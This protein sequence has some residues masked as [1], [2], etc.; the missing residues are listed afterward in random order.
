MA[1]SRATVASTA[2]VSDCGARRTAAVVIVAAAICRGPMAH[3]ATTSATGVRRVSVCRVRANRCKWCKAAGV[4]GVIIHPVVLR[5]AAACRNHNANAIIHCRRMV[6][7]IVRVAVRNIVRATHTHVHPVHWIHVSSSVTKWMAEISP[8]RVLLALRNGY[9]S[10]DV[11]TRMGNVV[12]SL[13][14]RNL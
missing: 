13:F 11:S 6:A 10:M 1:I 2:N 4:H 9:R 7:S 3:R 5:V 8:A 12:F 14:P